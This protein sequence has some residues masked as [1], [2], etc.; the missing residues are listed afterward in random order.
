MENIKF[1]D[2]G[3]SE[4]TMK[5]IKAKWFEEPS[6]IQAG[7]IPLLM[8]GKK[9]IIGQAQTGTGKTASF[10]IPIIEKLTGREK[11]VKAIILA[12]TRELAIQV[13]E[14]IHSFAGEK[15][16]NIALLYGGQS[17]SNEIRKLKTNPQIIV[18]TPGRVK[19][20]LNKWRL[21][22]KSIDYFVLDEADE[23]LN[24][25][26][27]EEIEEILET[28][29]DNK[30]VLLFSAT[31]PKAILDIAKKYMW[32][33]DKVTIERTNVSN[34]LIDQIYFEVA[35]N[36]K[37]EALSR[38]IDVEEDFY[39]IIFCRTKIEVD[40]VASKLLNR[41]YLAEWIHWDIDQKTRERILARF[42][43]KKISILVATDV[44]A[45]GIDVGNLTHVINY[46]LPES[47]ESYTHRIGRTG[48]AG[49]KGTAIS[50]VTRSENRRLFFIKNAT[51]TD[52]K[53]EILPKASDL[54]NIKKDRLVTKLKES[55]EKDIPKSYEK[56]AQDILSIW[57]PEKIIATLLSNFYGKDLDEKNYI[58]I[59][60]DSFSVEKWWT[61]RLF[62][63]K[64]RSHG[65]SAEDIRRFIEDSAGVDI[66]KVRDIEVFEDF[67][68]INTPFIE[69]EIILQVFKDLD[70]R[71]PVVV[72]AKARDNDRGGW[73][74]NNN[75]SWN[76]WGFRWSDR[77]GDSFGR[78]WDDKKRWGF[79]R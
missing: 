34:A 15:K 8:N 44:A 24:I 39:G 29:P 17:I 35:P 71:K 51:K 5:A 62:I 16:I 64:G 30:R 28:T 63:A 11:S 27:R 48:R 77:R 78:R 67:S 2:L 9:D 26:F 73:R 79:R 14:E 21:D 58:D 42:K 74:S 50:F 61:T 76:R 6:P 70:R 75:R 56:L 60:E 49:K 20:H 22:I 43:T 23:M 72:K 32:E 45:R 38:I 55:I 66:S 54:I 18:G 57:D 53:K 68:F 4:S 13:A 7:I 41:W 10:G 1:S 19:D 37:F 25:G 46:S 59:K 65:M 40:D 3:L 69:A 33:Y 31:M 12:P 52:L 47:A 36:D